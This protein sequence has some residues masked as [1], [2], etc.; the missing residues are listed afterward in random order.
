LDELDNV[1]T[2]MTDVLDELALTDLVTTTLAGVGDPARFDCARTWVK[3]AVLCPLANESG[4]FIGQTKVSGRGRMALRTTARRAVW[5]ALPH[6]AAR[7]HRLCTQADN[8]LR[9]GQ[10]SDAIAAALFRQLCIVVTRR[11]ASN[12]ANA[13]SRTTP[14]PNPTQRDNQPKSPRHPKSRP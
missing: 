2:R 8:P 13:A 10:A 1:Q 4:T 7:H 11:V 14:S 9:D 12:P 6:N 5:G 3:H